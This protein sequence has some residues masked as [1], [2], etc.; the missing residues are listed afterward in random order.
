MARPVVMAMMMMMVATSTEAAPQ[1][2]GLSSLIEKLGGDEE[3]GEVGTHE[4]VPYT[5]VQ[6]FDVRDCH[7]K[8]YRGDM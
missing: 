2:E 6:K 5:T 8:L 3:P 7:I 1:Y 4:Q